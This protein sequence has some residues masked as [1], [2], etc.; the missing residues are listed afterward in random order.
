MVENLTTY[1]YHIF[2]NF[3]TYLEGAIEQV[4]TNRI[5]PESR[6]IDLISDECIGFQYSIFGMGGQMKYSKKIF[7]IY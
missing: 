5:E 4:S 7:F 6:Y 3:L 2:Q 1:L